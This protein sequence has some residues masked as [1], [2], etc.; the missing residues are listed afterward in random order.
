MSLI[1]V[2]AVHAAIAAQSMRTLFF[3]TVLADLL[4][5]GGGIPLGRYSLSAAADSSSSA[6]L[7]AG[8]LAANIA[9][10]GVLFI[11]IACT[12]LLSHRIIRR[13]FTPVR[14]VKVVR[15]EID[16]AESEARFRR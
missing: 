3:M 16:T 4:V 7:I 10:L 2:S 8:L 15:G 14:T 1:R 5:F 9:L 12:T 11:A 6:L 13:F